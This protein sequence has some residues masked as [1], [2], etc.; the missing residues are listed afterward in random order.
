MTGYE[1][2]TEQDTSWFHP[3]EQT[4]KSNTLPSHLKVQ[5]STQLE[6]GNW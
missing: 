6:I 5:L 2:E 3:A 1:T 4:F